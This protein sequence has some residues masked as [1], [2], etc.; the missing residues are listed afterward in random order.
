MGTI[1]WCRLQFE[2]VEAGSGSLDGR[3]QSVHRGKPFKLK[4][5]LFRRSV[6]GH[7]RKGEVILSVTLD[8]I[9]L[10]ALALGLSRGE[11]QGGLGLVEALNLDG[12]PSSQLR[13]LG[14]D[15]SRQWDIA[16]L[17]GVAD[18]IAIV[19]AE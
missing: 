19:P 1:L 11:E 12:G 7:T 14:A 15:E 10:N 18:A 13:I 8:P 9:D 3:L 5:N 4:P 17:T 2:E 16:G 6:I